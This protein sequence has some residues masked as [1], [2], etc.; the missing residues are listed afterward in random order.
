[1][2]IGYHIR[3]II[4]GIYSPV[5]L[6]ESQQRRPFREV[7]WISFPSE[8]I[9]HAEIV[10]EKKRRN[11]TRWVKVNQKLF[12]FYFDH[13]RKK[14][15]S[16]HDT[17]VSHQLEQFVRPF[18]THGWQKG[19]WAAGDSTPEEIIKVSFVTLLLHCIPEA[20]AGCRPQSIT[21]GS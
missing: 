11:T 17:A 12:F 10:P 4:W 19:G 2:N 13:N 1:M 15:P 14:S 6:R 3:F 20:P 16:C 21:A 7:G 18:V 8:N 9:N 5:I